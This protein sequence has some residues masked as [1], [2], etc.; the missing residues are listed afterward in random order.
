MP[1]RAKRRPKRPQGAIY[2][3]PSGKGVS[4][5]PLFLS[6]PKAVPYPIQ[7]S[8]FCNPFAGFSR[9]RSAVFSV[10]FSLISVTQAGLWRGF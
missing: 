2:F 7:V 6:H 9:F 8:L 3:P 5:E 1:S 4:C 10:K